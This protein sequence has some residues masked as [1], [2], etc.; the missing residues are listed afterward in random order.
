[1]D[2]RRTSAVGFGIH[3]GGHAWGL[4]RRQPD[5]P[6]GIGGGSPD[7]HSYSAHALSSRSETTEREIVSRS[8]IIF[9][10]LHII[11]KGERV[12][13]RG[14]YGGYVPR[15]LLFVG[16]MCLAPGFHQPASARLSAKLGANGYALGVATLLGGLLRVGGR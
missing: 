1:M 12:R 10:A 2:A 13:Y 7:R 9:R 16:I 5:R 11:E 8:P 6:V 14:R 4:G 3:F 15:V